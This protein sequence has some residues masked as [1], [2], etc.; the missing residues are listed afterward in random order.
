[1]TDSGPASELCASIFELIFEAVN[2][3]GDGL[4]ALKIKPLDVRVAVHS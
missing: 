3:A 4:N 1:M 2:D